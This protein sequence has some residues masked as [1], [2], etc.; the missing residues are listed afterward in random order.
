MPAARGVVLFA[1]GAVALT[2]LTRDRRAR[3][4]TPSPIDEVD[5]GALAAFRD[6]YGDP[7]LAAIAVVIAAYNEAEGLRRVLATMPA[8]VCGLTAD[9][10]VVDD[11]SSD[12]TSDVVRDSGDAYAVTCAANRGQGAALRLGYRI[13]RGH[14]ARY[15]IT[16]DADGQYDTTDFPLVLSP[17]LDGSADFVTGSRRLGRHQSDDQFRRA[18]VYVFAWVVSALIGKRLTDTSFGLR[19]MRAELT[20]DVNLAQ[21]QYQSAELL[22]GAYAHGYRIIEVPGTMRARAAGTSKKGGN[23]VYALR[24]ARVVLRTWWRDIGLDPVG[25]RAPARREDLDA[26]QTP[27]SAEP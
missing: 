4:P 22:I 18:G 20:A 11:G 9:V 7:P 12:G 16:T 5:R 2:A 14:G 15:I 8:T 27:R 25:R 6:H 13:A 3:A 19:A 10:I 17:V 24:Y 23:V 21:P 1:V 26:T